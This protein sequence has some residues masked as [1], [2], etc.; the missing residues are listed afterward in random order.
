MTL[1]SEIV[2][3][4]L[5]VDVLNG[6]SA[7]D[8]AESEARRLVLLVIENR[9]ASVLILQ[10]RLHLLEFL[11]IEKYRVPLSFHYGPEQ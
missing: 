3:G 9:N 11:R 1:E 10:R 6:D 5:G 4:V 2:F 8:A 7:F